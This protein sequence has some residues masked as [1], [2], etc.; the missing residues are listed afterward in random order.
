M[1]VTFITDKDPVLRHDEQILTE[2]QKLQARKNIEAGDRTHWEEPINPYF[3]GDITG[4]ETVQMDEGMYLVKM[5]DSVISEADCIGAELIVDIGGEQQTFQITDS[6]I[7]DLTESLGVSGFCIAPEELGGQAVFVINESATIEGITLTKGTYYFCA[8]GVGHTHY[9][10]ALNGIV[11][12]SIIHKLPNKFLDLEW[13]PGKKTVYSNREEFVAETVL[14]YTSGTVSKDLP[15][16]ALTEGQTYLVNWDGE[17]YECTAQAYYEGSTHVYLWLG[18]AGR[19]GMPGVADSGEPFFI[20]DIYFN[21]SQLINGIGVQ[22]PDHDDEQT[23][24]IKIDKVDVTE[25]VNK[26]PVEY[27]PEHLPYSEPGVTTNTLTF[28]GNVTGKEIVTTVN[29]R[30]VKVSTEPCTKEDLIGGTYVLT[31]G[32]S[33]TTL[34]I[35][36]ESIYDY[37]TETNPRPI[38]ALGQR[39]LVVQE[40]CTDTTLKASFTK[41]VYF[42]C[43]EGGAYVSSLA[44][45]NKVFK[46]VGIVHKLDEKFLPNSVPIVQSANVGQLLAVKAVDE[47]GRPTEWGLVTLSI[48]TD[49]NGVM[50]II[51]T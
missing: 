44:I 32:G 36:E 38:L 9:F 51:A 31:S 26:L 8:E 34:T 48:T 16:V 47:T 30:Y 46:T 5:T 42:S 15:D 49:E 12:G 50:S 45:T 22:I 6:D 10:S 37:S 11:R 33:D 25:E 20:S 4:R 24:T 19:A 27:L 18:N 43:V 7:V 17:D 23:H 35:S 2:E 3:D 40:D 41:G 21:G 28:D 39:V 13:I 14:T 1:S 29:N